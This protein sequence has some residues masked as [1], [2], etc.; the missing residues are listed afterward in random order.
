MREKPARS[1]HILSLTALYVLGDAV[2]FLPGKGSGK[3]LFLGAVVAIAVTFLLYGVIIS[4]LNLLLQKEEEWYG[5][6]AAWLLSVVLA[7]VAFYMGVACL[8]RFVRFA[9]EIL[10]PKTPKIWI[11]LI[12]LAV[13]FYLLMKQEE[14]TKKLS[15][16]LFIMAVLIVLLILVLSEKDFKISNIA[17]YEVPKFGDLFKEALPFLKSITLPAL[18]IP[19]YTAIYD[20][21]VSYSASFGGL[22]FGSGLLIACF[23]EC[24]LLFGVELSARFDYPLYSAVSTVTVGPLFTRMDGMVYG[25]FFSTAL[26]KTAVS[27]RLAIALFRRVRKKAGKIRHYK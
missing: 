15:L 8:R 14:V 6:I 26:M 11:V 9:S 21:K 13:V 5:K 25:L 3:Y 22:A 23:A 4:L 24:L 7:A 27:F 19:A 20:R 16:L 2:I 1:K 12:F 10:L 18:L 17:I